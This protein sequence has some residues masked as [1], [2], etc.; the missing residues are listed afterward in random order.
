MSKALDKN[1][2]EVNQKMLKQ[3]QDFSNEL[4][5]QISESRER[6][7]N[8][9]QELSASKVDKL[10]LSEMLNAMALQVNPENAK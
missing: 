3:S 8:H 1:S 4:N 9:R 5:N 2:R 7:D 10:L 6:M